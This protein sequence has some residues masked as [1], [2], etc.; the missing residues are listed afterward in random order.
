MCKT[1]END[2]KKWLK[3]F[4]S[5][6]GYSMAKDRIEPCESYICKGQCKKGRDAYHSGYCQKC[7]KYRPRVRKH[8]IHRKKQELEKIRKEERY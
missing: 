6:G 4:V 5:N 1:E 2:C 7:G 3:R 8:H